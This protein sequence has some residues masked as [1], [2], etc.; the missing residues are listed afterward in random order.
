VVKA[1][2]QPRV[3]HLKGGVCSGLTRKRLTNLEGPAR[4][5]QSN[6][7]RILSY[8]RKRFDNI[9]SSLIN[10]DLKSL[11]VQVQLMKLAKQMSFSD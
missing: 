6:S 1:L 10:C 5:K 7:F 3:E 4:D 11:I 9:G 2:A 8:N